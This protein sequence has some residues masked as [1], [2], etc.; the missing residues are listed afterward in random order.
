MCRTLRARFESLAQAHNVADFSSDR[1]RIPF[2]FRYLVFEAGQQHVDPQ[3]RKT[4]HVHVLGERL[5]I[6]MLDSMVVDSVEGEQTRWLEEQLQKYAHIPAKLVTY[7][8]PMF[9]SKTNDLAWMHVFVDK[10][11]KHWEPLFSRYNVT[12][13]HEAHQHVLKRTYAIAHGEV[14]GNSNSSAGVTYIGDGA[15]GALEAGNLTLSW[16]MESVPLALQHVFDMKLTDTTLRASA[17]ALNANLNPIFTV[18][19]VISN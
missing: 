10:A 12:V 13:V 3:E 16:Y 2:F 1:D 7:H 9:P 5:L 14:V 8:Y 18:E 15:M 4:Y 6:I 11:R 17:I 19:K